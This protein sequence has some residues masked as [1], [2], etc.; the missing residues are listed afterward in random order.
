M[1][2]ITFHADGVLET[3]WGKGRW[4]EASTEKRPNTVF[5]DFIGQTHLLSFTGDSFNSIRCSDGEQVKGSLGN[6]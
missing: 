5:A 4:G 2:W 6:S 1:W 3:P